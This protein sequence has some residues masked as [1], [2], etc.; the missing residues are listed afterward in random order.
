MD[1]PAFFAWIR[2][3]GTAGI[4]IVVMIIF[5][6]YISSRDATMEKALDKMTEAFNTLTEVLTGRHNND[7]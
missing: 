2:D 5:L 3:V 1:D 4:T 7:K 6:R